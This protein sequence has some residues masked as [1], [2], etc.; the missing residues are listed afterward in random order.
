VRFSVRS[1]GYRIFVILFITASVRFE[2][3]AMPSGMQHHV[4]QRKF[5]LQRNVPLP[6]TV[7][8]N[9]VSRRPERSRLLSDFLLGLPFSPED[10]GSMF[11]RNVSGIVPSYMV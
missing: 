1:F 4:I 3:L 6:S 11:L 2:L 10:G 7:S 9:K 8:K 5:M